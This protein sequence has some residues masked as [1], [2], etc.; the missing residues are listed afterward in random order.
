MP[1]K[2][3][4]SK[5]PIYNPPKSFP[6]YKPPISL[7]IQK[8]FTTLP[9]YKPP[10]LVDTIKQGFGFGLGS[11]VAHKAV[12][13]FMSPREYTPCVENVCDKI[14]KEFEKCNINLNCSEELVKEYNKCYK[15]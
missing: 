3:Y 12:D 10:T 6:I 4:R 2:D 13:S 8:P 1:R 5:S 9:L 11:A 15:L 14:K 7:P